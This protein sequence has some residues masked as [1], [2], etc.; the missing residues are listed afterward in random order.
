MIL[1]NLPMVLRNFDGV[2]S[3]VVLLPMCRFLVDSELRVRSFVPH[4]LDLVLVLLTFL[5][6]VQE[7]V[8]LP[9]VAVLLQIADEV[10]GCFVLLFDW[11]LVRPVA[12][13]NPLLHR[14]IFIDIVQ[15]VIIIS[16]ERRHLVIRA[17]DLGVGV[18]Q[19]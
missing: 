12:H 6:L 9:T 5:L 13:V 17:L 8:E 19:V 18:R 11:D 7:V 14:S 3:R 1:G 4:R 10:V 16:C 15:S 2:V